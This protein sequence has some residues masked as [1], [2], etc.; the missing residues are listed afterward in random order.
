M[1]VELGVG[2]IVVDQIT[3]EVGL[4]VERY[5]LTNRG[6]TDPIALW[7]WDVYWIG[8]DIESQKRLVTWTEYGLINII[9]TGTL[10]HYKNIA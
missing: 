5:L 10:L 2:D 1:T 7:A 6:P 8:K 9:K 4:L 3:S